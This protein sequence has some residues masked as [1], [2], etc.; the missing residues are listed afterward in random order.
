MVILLLLSKSKVMTI[1]YN[2]GT[3]TDKSI[4]ILLNHLGVDTN[5]LTFENSNKKYEFANEYATEISNWQRKLHAPDRAKIFH[6]IMYYIR[7]N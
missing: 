5:H 4:E 7:N 3:Q 2:F 1:K 6:A